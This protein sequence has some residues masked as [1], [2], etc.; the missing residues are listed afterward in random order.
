M[1]AIESCGANDVIAYPHTN[2]KTQLNILKHVL[3]L[4]EWVVQPG[5]T[6][7]ASQAPVL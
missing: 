6:L 1:P 2:C 7:W 3:N 4:G 5:I